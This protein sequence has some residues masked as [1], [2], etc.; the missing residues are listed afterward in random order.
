LRVEDRST[1]RERFS[2]QRS[3]LNPDTH[4]EKVLEEVSETDSR[5]LQEILAYVQTKTD[6]R[7]IDIINNTG[8]FEIV[9]SKDLGTI[10]LNIYST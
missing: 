10:T 4:N 2:P 8:S 6:K 1:Q 7:T 3:E 5:K 9:S